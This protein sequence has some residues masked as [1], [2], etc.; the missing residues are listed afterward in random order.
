MHDDG[1]VWGD[2]VVERTN[3]RA[4]MKARVLLI[5]VECAFFLVS[6]ERRLAATPEVG[7]RRQQ[8][9]LCRCVAMFLHLF[10]AEERAEA[11]L[12]ALRRHISVVVGDRRL[13]SGCMLWFVFMSRIVCAAQV[14]V[15]CIFLG[16][17][18]AQKPIVHLHILLFIHLYLEFPFI[19]RV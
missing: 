17:L 11:A 15:L 13:C 19:S 18:Q 16:Y 1:S 3:I 6:Y 8:T 9:Y 10:E 7:R 2:L 14:G 4:S 5:S 12:D